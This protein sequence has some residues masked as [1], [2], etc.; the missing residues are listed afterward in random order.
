MCLR[1]DSKKRQSFSHRICDDLCEEILKYLPL[2]DKLRL[3]CVSQQFQMTVLKKQSKLHLKVEYEKCRYQE[4]N[5]PDLLKL[6]YPSEY[7]VVP[8]IDPQLEVIAFKSCY[9]KPIESLLKKCPNIQSIDLYGFH[10][11]NQ[12]LK[13][14]LQMI[15]KYCNH[16]IKFKGMPFIENDCI[17]SQEFYRKFGLKLKYFRSAKH[18]FDFNLFPNIESINC[19]IDMKQI[20]VEEVIQLNP[21]KK[22]KKLKIGIEVN[23]EHLLPQVMQ[24]FDKLTHLSLK[25]ITESL[26][27]VFKDFPSHQ[28]LKDL[29]ISF[30]VNQDFEGMCYSLKQIAIKCPKLKRIVFSSLIVLRNSSDVK[31]L[32]QLLKAFPA[33]KRL[34]ISL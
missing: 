27:K 12:I 28:N 8:Q 18:V 10:S 7:Q 31:Q 14:M 3:E 20:K 16:L 26:N 22:L 23:K 2:K 5:E 34:N 29:F 1:S 24:K 17:E 13:P 21:L 15:T 4:T 30:R 32:F 11:N 6:E 25:L 9:H 33:L 19:M